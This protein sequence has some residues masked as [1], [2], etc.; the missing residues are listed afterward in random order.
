MA[1]E[2]IMIN[3]TTDAAKKFNEVK[4]KSKNPEDAMLRVSFGGYG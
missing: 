2:N 1:G 4:Q 3:V